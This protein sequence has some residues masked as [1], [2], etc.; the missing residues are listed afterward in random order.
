MRREKKKGAGVFRLITWEGF[1]WGSPWVL[2][3]LSVASSLLYVLDLL[4]R[5]DVIEHRY[6]GQQL[7]SVF[8]CLEGSA[9]AGPICIASLCSVVFL[10]AGIYAQDFQE[11]AV[12][13]RI[14]R[15]G[16]KRYAGIRTLQMCISSWLVGC[17]GILLAIPLAAVMLHEPAVSPDY[18]ECQGSVFFVRGNF[19]AFLAVYGCI[20]GFRMMFYALMTFLCSYFVP[21]RRVLMALPLLLWHFNQYVIQQEWIPLYLQPCRVFEVS[22][23]MR[24]DGFTEW[25]TLWY[26]IVVLLGLVVTVW[27]V[28][29]ARL[30]K[31]GIFGGEHCE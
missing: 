11:S 4:G 30:R 2:L 13:M 7:T 17:C 20:A 18:V 21:Q 10:G 6:A 24:L 22:V 28:S 15:M 29:V 12:Y 14:Q 23:P 19:W 8:I 31:R 9:Y 1:R 5:F 3:V 27:F 25:Q 26:R 16:V